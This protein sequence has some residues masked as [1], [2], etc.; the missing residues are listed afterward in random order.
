[1]FRFA[2]P[3]ILYS[4][5]VILIVIGIIY[6]IYRNRHKKILEEFGDNELVK[7]LTPSYSISKIRWKFWLLF[8]AIFFLG[9]GLGGPQLG[10]KLVTVKRKGIEIVIALDVSNSM[11][12]EDIKPNRLTAAKRAIEKLIDKLDND[13]I[14]LVI[15]AGKAYVQVPVTADYVSAKMFLNTISTKSVPIQGTNLSEAL[16]MAARSF[17]SDKDISKAII[18]I[19]DGENHDDAAVETAKEI[20]AQGI[21]IYTVGIGSP[22]GVPIPMID[23]FGRKV[24]KTDKDGNVVVTKLNEKT[25]QEIA[26]IGNGT[27]VRAT[28][29]GIGLNLIYDELNKLDKKEIESKI[30]AEYE[31]YFQP[32]I[33]IGILLLFIEVLIPLRKS[34]FSEKYNLFKIKI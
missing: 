30:Y 20:A 9:I 4:L 21:R 31:N 22:Q 14:G 5:P 2:Y 32:F 6:I 15:F 18:L 25:L 27:Y 33:A 26:M 3:Y 10:S 7:K 17:T 11:L 19:T 29:S 24:F 13:R 12:A 1:M 23:K 28:N 8:F 34:K 16:Q